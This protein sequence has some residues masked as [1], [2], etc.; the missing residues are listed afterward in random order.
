VS[1]ELLERAFVV[2][3]EPVGKPRMTRADKWKT[4]PV[5]MRYRAFADELRLV[6][7]RV[8]AAPGSLVV[9]AFFERPASWSL[10]K[11]AEMAGKPHQSKP[12]AD[13]VLK[14]VSDALYG[15]DKSIW[16][17]RIEKFWAD[18]HGPRTEVIVS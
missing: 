1:E 11:H 12:D 5:V 6:A 4:R 15:E 16:H 8:P 10:K 7:G 17:M 14:A 3:R 2:R 9:R 13:N 18:E